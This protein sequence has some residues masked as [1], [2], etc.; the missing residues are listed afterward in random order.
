MKHLARAFGACVAMAIPVAADADTNPAA[1][2]P[3]Y[4]AGRDAQLRGDC[5]AVV[6]HFSAFLR[7]H[8]HVKERYRAFYFDVQEAI[9]RC[10]GTV[11]V[12]G[13]GDKSK[14]MVPLPDPPPIGD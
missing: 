13:I 8:P 1:K 12:R 2:Y 3:N 7:D 5:G 4:Y 14:K 10:S 11:R 9:G 6:E